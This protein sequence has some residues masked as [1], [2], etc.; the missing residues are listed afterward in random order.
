M[1]AIASSAAGAR[2]PTRLLRAVFNLV[3]GSLLC[4][5]PLT[6][7]LVLGWLTRRMAARVH[8]RLERPADHNGWVLGPRGQGWIVR[9]LGG[10]ASNI[11]AG[12]VSAAGLA[13]LTLP[14]T[15]LWLGAWWAGW[16]TSFNK[17]YEQSAVGPISWLIGAI[18]A[19]PILAHLPLAL[20]HA[21]AEGRFG[22][23]FEYRRI[24][25]VFTAAGWRMAWLAFL[26]VGLCVTL[27][28]LRA[29]PVFIEGIVPGFADM[30]AAEQVQVAET[31]DVTGAALTFLIVLFLRDRASSIYAL[32]APRAARGR[33]AAV[34]MDHAAFRT[35]C[36]GHEPSRPMAA[37]WLVLSCVIWT[38][39]PVLIVM[40]QF[41]NYAPVL[42]LTHPVF[43]LPWAG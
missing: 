4:L 41:M 1:R 24:R 3:V 36:R 18:I 35:A 12:V 11:R 39:L 5:S 33:A 43:F 14:F 40:S 30:T 22:A 6:A 29:L 7:L 20:A 28:G 25:S 38:G 16:E 31:F 2:L 37:L 10:L 34:W 23:F 19:L 13:A 27:L 8:V 9:L 21:S 17:G 26:S 15:M 32:A 42:W